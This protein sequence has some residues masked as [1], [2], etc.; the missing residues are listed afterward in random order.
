M[1]RVFDDLLAKKLGG[2]D[3]SQTIDNITRALVSIDGYLLDQSFDKIAIYQDCIEDVFY[4]PRI[5]HVRDSLDSGVF[6]IF[7]QNYTEA[8]CF[9]QIKPTEEGENEEIIKVANTRSGDIFELQGWTCTCQETKRTG[10]PCP[11]LLA[12]AIETK[13]LSYMSLIKERWREREQ[14]TVSESEAVDGE[15]SQNLEEAPNNAQVETKNTEEK[16]LSDKDKID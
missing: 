10:L 5:K 8:V 3:K 7:I 13:E 11:H 15:L 4:D 16:A 12:V 9:T 2:A 6:K 1:N 14:S